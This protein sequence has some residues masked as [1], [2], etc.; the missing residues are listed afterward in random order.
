[1]NMNI[2]FLL[3]M[4]LSFAVNAQSQTGNTASNNEFVKFCFGLKPTPLEIK[5]VVQG[6]Q[7]TAYRSS[8]RLQ[9][10]AVCTAAGVYYIFGRFGGK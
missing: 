5:Y 1:M 8:A 10:I 2:R 9:Q 4:F 7:L 6:N 3:A